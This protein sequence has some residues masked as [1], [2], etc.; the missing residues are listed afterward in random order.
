M[1]LPILVVISGPAGTGKT[2]LAHALARTVNCPVISRDEIK[3]GM[4]LARTNYA[5]APGDAETLRTLSVFFDALRLMLDNGV[6]VVAEAA[7]QQPVWSKHLTPLLNV[8][9]LRV[10]Q[11]HTDIDTVVAR[12]AA[13]GTDRTAHADASLGADE[14]RRRY[15]TDFSRLSLDVPT[16][17]VD[18]T[19]G[20]EPLLADIAIFARS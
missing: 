17:D 18:T 1:T 8:C 15:L 2:T 20:Y 14:A 10:V 6:S 9:R 5:A 7:F 19:D 16:L 4:V 3:E 13:R 11:C 12:I